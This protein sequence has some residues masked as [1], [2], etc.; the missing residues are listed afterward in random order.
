MSEYQIEWDDTILR[1]V[2]KNTKFL[3]PG[4]LIYLGSDNEGSGAPTLHIVSYTPNS[5]KPEE[6][7]GVN[8][9]FLVPMAD[10]NQRNWEAWVRA[11]YEDVWSH[12]INEML[13]FDGVRKFAPHHGNQENPYI[14]WH[15]GDV[16][17]T[18]VPAG[19]SKEEHHRSRHENFQRLKTFAAT[20]RSSVLEGRSDEFQQGLE[21]AIDMINDPRE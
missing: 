8:H 21:R 12:E 10:Y 2:V 20:R 9:S 11:R 18:D 16:E 6:M 19:K 3:M 1:E 15:I 5:Y 17:D 7:I 14:T 13:L 4:W